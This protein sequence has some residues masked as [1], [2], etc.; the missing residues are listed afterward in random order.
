LQCSHHFGSGCVDGK[1]VHFQQP[2]GEQRV[3]IDGRSDAYEPSGVLA[4]YVKIL[5]QDP[6]AP[7][8][9]D[10]HAVRS[11]LVERNGP[12]RAWLDTQPEWQ[13]VY[14]DD[15]SVIFER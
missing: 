10:K 2:E 7:A 6:Q 8:L 14:Q 5:R 15:L 4:D 12:L 11:C 9:L 1:R 3:F 13:R